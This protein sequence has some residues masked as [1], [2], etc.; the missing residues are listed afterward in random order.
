M[1]HHQLKER[2]G[3]PWRRLLADTVGDIPDAE[4]IT[5]SLSIA[6]ATGDS[7]RLEEIETQLKMLAE[8]K[9]L[10]VSAASWDTWRLVVRY[11]FEGARAAFLSLILLISACA[12]PGTLRADAVQDAVHRV[13]ERHDALLDSD[14]SNDPIPTDALELED[15]LRTSRMLRELVDEA[16]AQVAGS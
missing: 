10:R 7:R 15:W 4:E 14:P 1:D 2:L 11:L 5:H 8:R 3:E 13:T 6:I 9:R 12:G 16:A